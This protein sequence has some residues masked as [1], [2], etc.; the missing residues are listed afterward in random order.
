MAETVEVCTLAQAQLQDSPS[1]CRYALPAM[2]LHVLL[3]CLT[4]LE[5][6]AVAENVGEGGATLGSNS[7]VAYLLGNTPQHWAAEDERSKSTG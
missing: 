1:Q 6:V 7:C 3:A 4:G 5:G 2:G